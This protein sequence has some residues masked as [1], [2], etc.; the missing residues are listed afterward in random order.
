[1][2]NAFFFFFVPISLKQ[3]EGVEGEDYFKNGHSTTISMHRD[4][5]EKVKIGCRDWIVDIHVQSEQKVM[6]MIYSSIYFSPI[7]GEL[8]IYY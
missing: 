2:K 4:I 5:I 7:Q 3:K 1:M 6:K 8:Y